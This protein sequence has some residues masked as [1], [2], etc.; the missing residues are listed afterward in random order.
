MARTSEYVTVAVSGPLRRT[1]TYRL[2]SISTTLQPGQRV[3]VPFG[4]AR[5]VGF[6]LG[7]GEPIGSL[8]IKEIIRFI[9]EYSLFPKELFR[10]C[11]W[12]ADYYFANPADCLQTVLPPGMKSGHQAVYYYSETADRSVSLPAWLEPLVKPGRPV[13]ISTLRRIKSQGGRLLTRLRQQEVITEVWPEVSSRSQRKAAGYRVA[14]VEKWHL[15]FQ[16]KGFTPEPFDGTRTRKELTATGFSDYRIRQSVADGL[17]QPVYHDDLKTI[18]SFIEPRQDVASLVLNDEQQSVLDTLK[19]DLNSGFTTGLLHGI[20]GSG[21]TLVYCHLAR[22]VLRQSKTVLVLTPEIALAGTTL[23]YF[24]GFFGGQVTVVHSAMTPRERMAGWRGVREGKF[25]V[26]VGPRSALLTPLPDLGL[27]VVDEEHDSSYK[28]NDP[29]PRFHGRDTAIMR[30][31]FNDI[32]VLLGSASPSLESYYNT[33]TGRYRLLRLTRR[34]GTT[35]LPT[36]KVVDMR[37][38]RIRGDLPFL[39]YPLKKAVERRLQ[40]DEQVI[41]YLNRRGHSPQLK[42]A[43]CGH[44]PQCPQC[45]VN[46]T[47]HKAGGKLSCH[48]CGHLAAGFSSCPRC[49]GGD[50][51]YL[52]AGTQKVEEAVGRLFTDARAVRFDSD[53]VAGRTKAHQVLTRFAA[54]EHNLLLGTQ[55]VTKG[56]DLPGV[57]LVGVLAADLSLDLPDFR[58]S[59]RTFMQLLQVAGRCGRADKPGEVLIQ[60]FYPDSPV[61]NEAAAQDYQTFFDRE[62]KSRR[63]LHYPPTARLV[64]FVL[65]STNEKQLE[66]AITSFRDRL[67]R[68]VDESGV[69]VTILGPAPCPMYFLRGRYRRQLIV[70]TRQVIKLLKT[71]TDWENRRPRFKL[72]SSVRIAVDVDAQDMM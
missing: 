24:R 17:L 68:T 49:G 2:P 45:R 39:S 44:V 26:V 56:L 19:A 33:R 42:C 6:Y 18:L 20:T 3:L 62:I 34:P 50:I 27:I 21:K 23:A 13:A 5:K 12:M 28:Q 55:M 71:L 43:S 59:E 65:S 16:K 4:S 36:V 61:I 48:Y 32:P 30:A 11:C 57:T 69:K 67:N 7:P 25:R 37:K 15:Y 10:L 41:L 31:R 64:N 9:D 63:E 29:A 72:P 47:W 35:S 46:L 40:N 22:E 14:A 58:A 51:L 66:S 8:K 52:G 53:S 60:T 70:K 38:E 54:G 1:F